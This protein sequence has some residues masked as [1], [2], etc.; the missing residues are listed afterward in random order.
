MAW[1][2][3]Q[4]DQMYAERAYLHWYTKEGMTRTEFLEARDDMEALQRQY[5]GLAKTS[6]RRRRRRN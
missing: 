3:R 1:L 6:G 4:F 5:A 2:N